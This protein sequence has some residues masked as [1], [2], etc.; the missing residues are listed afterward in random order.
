[1]MNKDERRTII[2]LIYMVNLPF[3]YLDNPLE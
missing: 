1:V 3:A 2:S